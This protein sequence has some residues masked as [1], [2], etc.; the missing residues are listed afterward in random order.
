MIPEHLRAKLK[1]QLLFFKQF[2]ESPLSVGAVIPSSHFL[3]DRML[4]GEGEGHIK[5]APAHIVELGPGTGA[6]TSAALKR[7][8]NVKK[9]WAFEINPAF[10]EI[11]RHRFPEITIIENGAQHAVECLETA[12]G[13][14]DLVLSGLPFANIPLALNKE[15]IAATH[16]IMKEGAT[17]STFVY[18]HTYQL[19][20]LREIRTYLRSKFKTV[21]VTFVPYNVP[22]AFVIKCVK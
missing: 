21:D 18:I 22:P 13:S 6:F 8:P 11:L 14:I 9:Y 1:H 7:F 19:P 2:V 10:R 17:F 16:A 15:I 5:A 20:K 3:A 4:E 12:A